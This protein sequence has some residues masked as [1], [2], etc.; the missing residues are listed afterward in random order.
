MNRRVSVILWVSL[1]FVQAI[2]AAGLKGRIDGIVKDLPKVTFSIHIAKAD[3]RR[4]VYSHRAHQPVIPASNMKIVTSAAA[5]HYLGPDFEYVTK[6]GLVGDTLVVIGSGDP[7]LGDR[8]VDHKKGRV[9]GWIMADIVA[10]L[11]QAGRTRIKDLIVDSSVFD[12]QRVHPSWPASELNRSFS[13]EVYGINYNGNCIGMTVRNTQGRIVIDIEP[14]TE[15]VEISNQVRLIGSGKGAVGAYRKAGRPN[16]LVVRGK[17]RKQQGPFAVAIEQPAVFFGYM[18]AEQ[19]GASGIVVGGQL[20]ER[21]FAVDAR[22]R[23]LAEYRTPLSLCLQ[24]C[25]KDSFNLAAEA[26][27]KTVAAHGTPGHAQGTWALGQK[28]VQGY[29]RKLGVADSEHRID[30]GSGLSRDNR[31]SAHTITTVLSSIYRSNNWDFYESSLAVGGRDGTLDKDFLDAKYQGKIFGKSGYLT[32]VRAFSGICTTDNGDYVFSILA[33]NAY[34]LKRTVYK[35]AQ[36]I[37]DCN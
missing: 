5:L 32:G 7:L 9:R 23:L 2:S 29:L 3:S 18:L 11:R 26:L 10:Q 36:T 12:D 15:F 22:F 1:V 6:V 31:L 28:R 21:G 4:T 33:N 30:D 19:L 37:I 35:I 25:N 34:A 13:A 14:R 20:V 17:C 27:L 16:S 8:E 24:R